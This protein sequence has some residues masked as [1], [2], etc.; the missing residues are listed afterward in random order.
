[1]VKVSCTER[2]GQGNDFELIPTVKIG[3]KHRESYFG[4]KF[5]AIR[6]HCEYNGQ[7]SHNVK[8][9]EKFLRFFLKKK[10]PLMVQFSKFYS[11]SFHRDTDRRVVSEFIEIW[12]MG[13][14]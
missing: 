7:R 9:F 8:Y 1:M 4:S 5:P 6:N 12:L 11:E 13:N 10:Q 3:T 14:Q 2:T